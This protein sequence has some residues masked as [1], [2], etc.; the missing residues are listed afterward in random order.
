MLKIFKKGAMFGLEARVLGK[1]SGGLFLARLRRLT[2]RLVEGHQASQIKTSQ[3]AMF[4]LDA[5]IA[6]AIF[7]ALSV[8]SGAA[9]YSAIQDAK[10]T[11][12][13]ATH[14]EVTKAVEA[15]YLDTGELPY[16]I[17]KDYLQLDKLLVDPSIAGW[18]GPYTPLPKSTTRYLLI[19][20]AT[21]IGLNYGKNTDWA[22]RV[23]CVT[24]GAGETCSFWTSS[25]WHSKSLVKAVEQKIDKEDDDDTKNVRY[26]CSSDTACTVYIKQS[27]TTNL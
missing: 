19:A 4:G 16:G 24:M 15:Y 20:D 9:L 17:A 22:S 12:L 18:K 7:G 8:I 14:A 13:I 25:Q 27:I 3:G 2:F 10:A 1:Q 23:T 21:V 5:R 11:S 26:T 6:L